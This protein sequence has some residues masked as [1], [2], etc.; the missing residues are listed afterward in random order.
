[1]NDELIKK[2]KRERTELYP[3]GVPIQPRGCSKTYLYLS[4]FLRW[5]AYDYMCSIYEVINRK[6]TIE[7]AHKDIDEF[8]VEQM[9]I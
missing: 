3:N 9:P 8:V 1:M 7:E 6:Y 4:H 5:Y 2:L